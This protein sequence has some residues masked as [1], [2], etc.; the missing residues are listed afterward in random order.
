MLFRSFAM[1]NG[2]SPAQTI[3]RHIPVDICEH[4]IDQL[5][6]GYDFSEQIGNVR[7]LHCCALVC[8]NWRICSQM[9]LFR[10][11]ILHDVA[12]VH[13]FSAALESGPHLSDY[14]H[15][16]MLVGRTLETTASPLGNFP[17]ALHGKLP[18]LQTLDRKS[19]RL[20]SSHSGESRM[21]SSA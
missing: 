12:A 18:R 11:V 15:E 7:A 2:D 10:S 21:P 13:R 17:I 3:A 19:T 20:N 9:R 16:V 6:S 8:R 1:R 14:V 4:I 5:Y